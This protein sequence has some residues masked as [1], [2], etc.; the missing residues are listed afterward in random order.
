MEQA[1]PLNRNRRF[2]ELDL[3]RFV[4]A[5]EVM[6][7]HY[8]LYGFPHGYHPVDFS[9]LSEVL[10]YF[11][12]GLELLFMLSG[13]VILK[14]VQTKTAVGFLAARGVRLY[15][16]YWVCVS[17]TAVVVLLARPPLLSV[18]L[19]QYL[20]NLT[21]VQSAFG[22]EHIDGV[23]WTMEVQ[24]FYGWVFLLCLVKQIHNA[25]EFLGA[26]LL[27]AVCIDLFGGLTFTKLDYLLLPRLS[28]YFIAGAPSS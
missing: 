19:P 10:Q 11:Y 1:I 5:F 23:Y 27:A 28:F 16:T 24:V 14:T 8:T 9:A 18:D 17:L 25:G 22:F 21:M 7:F 15:P 2:Y 3:L 6:M 12:F 4:A 13:F 20:A 26:W